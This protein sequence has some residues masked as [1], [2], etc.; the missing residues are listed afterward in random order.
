M[1]KTV[2]YVIL[3][4]MWFT[5]V[6]PAYAGDKF[7]P[8]SLDGGYDNNCYTLSGTVTQNLTREFYLYQ[9]FSYPDE[10][11]EKIEKLGKGI[12]TCNLDELK[13]MGVEVSVRTEATRDNFFKTAEMNR[14]KLNGV[15]ICPS[16]TVV[17]NRKAKN[18]SDPGLEG[19]G[20]VYIDV[21]YK[22]ETVTKPIHFHF[23][24][25]Y[26]KDEE[27][28]G[29]NGKVTEI[30]FSYNDIATN[31]SDQTTTGS[32]TNRKAP[33][34]VEILNDLQYGTVTYEIKSY[35]N[36]LGNTTWAQLM[37]Y[38]PKPDCPNYVDEVIKI[39]KT[40]P[41][42]NDTKNLTADYV[43]EKT[44]T[45]H[46]HKSPYA[47]KIIDFLPAPGQF[48]NSQ[49]FLYDD[50]KKL[51]GV[52]NDGN[53]KKPDPSAM[54]SLGGFGGYVIF[55]FDQPIT[56]DPRHPYGVDFTINGNSF[57]PWEKGWWCEPAAVMVMEDKNGD[58]IPNDGEWYEL[59]GSDYWLKTTRRNIS[60]TYTNP[61]YNGRYT[62]PWT[63]SD[64]RAGA[65][66]TNNYHNQPYFP[67][68]EN[69]PSAKRDKLTFD[70]TQIMCSPDKRVPSYIEFY[71]APAFGY[72][73]NKGIY[74]KS[75]MT[76]PLN[77]YY[78]DAN[79]KSSDGFSLSWAVDKDGNYIDMQKADF[80]K[81]YTNG[82]FNAGWLG[83]WSSEV[84]GIALTSPDESY[85]AKDYYINYIGLNQIQVP[86]NHSYDF[87]GF[88]FKNGRPVSEG[89]ARWWVD[90]ESIASVDNSGHFTGLKTGKTN[91]H[92][93]QYADAPEDVV[94]IEVVELKGVMID[95]EGNAST[96]SN[97]NT[98]CVVGE[99]IFI[100]VESLTTCEE[101][102][103]GT[104]SNRYIYDSYTWEN[105]D[106]EVG[107]MAPNGLFTAKK[108]G[109]C[110]LTVHSVY[111]PAFTDKITVSV[112]DPTA[113]V[114]ISDKIKIPSKAPQGKAAI[115]DI[116]TNERGATIYLKEVMADA[117]VTL[118]A[119]G[120]NIA[121]DFTGKDYQSTKVTFTVSCYDK[122]YTYTLPVIFGPDQEASPARIIFAG[123]Q[124]FGSEISSDGKAP[125]QFAVSSKSMPDIQTEGAYAWIAE[126]KTIS[127]CLVSTGKIVASATLEN[128]GCHPMT[129]VDDKIAVADGKTIRFF[130]KTDLEDSGKSLKFD[131][132]VKSFSSYISEF[133]NAYY[134][135]SALYVLTGDNKLSLRKVVLKDMTVEETALDLGVNNAVVIAG[136]DSYAYIVTG[137]EEITKVSSLSG[138]FTATQYDGALKVAATTG[139]SGYILVADPEGGLNEWSKSKAV[140]SENPVM[141]GEKSVSDIVVSKDAKTYYVNYEGSDYYEEFSAKTSSGTV[142]YTATGNKALKPA[143]PAA[144]SAESTQPATTYMAAVT[145]ND[146]PQAKD[147]EVVEIHEYE[148]TSK[149]QRVN[150]YVKDYNNPS[151]Y[152]LD[153]KVYVRNAEEFPWISNFMDNTGY[154]SFNS[155]YP[156][157]ADDVE[158][159]YLIAEAIDKAGGS[160]KFSVPLKI[161]PWL[162][163][164]AITETPV[165]IYSDK[166][167]VDHTI[168]LSDVYML[169]DNPHLTRTSYKVADD[170]D[171]P[172]NVTC[173]IDSDND[174]LVHVK[175]PQ[176][177]VANFNLKV[178]RVDSFIHDNEE[179]ASY[180]FKKGDIPDKEYIAELPITITNSTGV[181]EILLKRSNIRYHAE[182][183]TISSPV[184]GTLYVYSTQGACVICRQ[185]TADGYVD[186][187]AL[188]PGVYA[189]RVGNSVAKIIVR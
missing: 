24:Y 86:V 69:Y 8:L 44:I 47:T 43:V 17:T 61:K 92:F 160:T 178:A 111:N 159:K 167:D 11:L 183:R 109:T 148:K 123:S 81:V 174:M 135:P 139:T 93:K 125:V 48:V 38:T 147:T 32:G 55:G 96:V 16:L 90:D 83:E 103:N 65:L 53:P 66:I 35:R 164:P 137:P 130:Y 129:I 64:G 156:D 171:F 50:A 101:S 46:L 58:G 142:S 161:T 41:K 158:Y 79:G 124:L 163:R 118:S 141:K 132:P 134:D 182:T 113:P 2:F 168:N 150:Y 62:V 120:N 127:R 106:P 75:D 52:D 10:I 7:V 128:T 59:A 51:L 136:D 54:I 80:V 12:N 172:E 173:S 186:A 45:L 145:E 99:Q 60:M 98:A 144:N 138:N 95:L 15:E 104:T 176:G 14:R 87:E 21:K 76:R 37:I 73:D 25:Y 112:T 105:S 31:R 19:D 184:A 74:N 126:D 82:S 27:I 121:Y 97:D 30:D 107:E 122:D 33:Y 180:G 57:E 42:A 152:S 181:S 133:K 114:L 165:T 39:R 67:L 1:K 185:I 72:S 140:F 78:D 85:K 9:L 91:L 146:N 188:T 175:A 28:D 119:D 89:T 153:Y 56:S 23:K 4:L 49:A 68:P 71:R 22:G 26:G 84:C 155:Q 154:F 116:L 189:A 110:V 29:D 177:T 187:S 149:S 108:A 143:A 100:N 34:S 151:Q 117:S 169:R 63:T 166:S 3:S 70:G 36:H 157:R 5:S 20:T 102:M 170:N 94:E 6:I 179:V 40:I 88:V 162:Y 13:E 18:Y 77:P 115:S 131:A